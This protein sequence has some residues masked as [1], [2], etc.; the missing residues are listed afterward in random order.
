ML[1]LFLKLKFMLMLSLCQ[2]WRWC[3]RCLINH[4]NHGFNRASGNVWRKYWDSRQITKSLKIK[5]KWKLRDIYKR[6]I[7]F[8]VSIMPLITWRMCCYFCLSITMWVATLARRPLPA[9]SQL[10]SSAL[11]SFMELMTDLLQYLSWSVWE[12]VLSSQFHAFKYDW[13][14]LGCLA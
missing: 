1:T 13:L 10:K 11:S 14:D 4:P 2:Y 3:E 12:A 7:P 6:M 9:P 8:V 5:S